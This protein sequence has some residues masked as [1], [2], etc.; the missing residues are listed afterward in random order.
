MKNKL[1]LEQ[2]AVLREK[3]TEKPFTGKYWSNKDKGFYVCAA[4]VTQLFSPDTKFDSG[5][6]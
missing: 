3:G 5:T 4:C 6:G 1:T 2:Y